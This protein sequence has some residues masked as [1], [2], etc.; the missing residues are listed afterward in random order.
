[1]NYRAGQNVCALL[2][3]HQHEEKVKETG[4]LGG[5]KAWQSGWLVIYGS[6]RCGLDECMSVWRR[7]SN[8]RC[9]CVRFILGFE[10]ETPSAAA[11]DTHT[12]AQ[13]ALL[14]T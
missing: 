5:G 2:G 1:M 11:T 12:S 4:N 8:G 6:V 3:C 14:Y 10:L 7:E 13:F 9:V